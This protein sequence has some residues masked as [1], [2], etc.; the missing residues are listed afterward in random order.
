MRRQRVFL[1]GFM[2]SGK[3][4]VGPLLAA[5]L[6][7]EF[8]DLDQQIEEQQGRSIRLL[9]ELEGEAFFRQIESQALQQLKKR[10]RCVVALGGGAFALATN[11][12]TIQS[13]GYSVFLDCPLEVILKR[14][15]AD[16]SRPLLQSPEFVKDL[17]DSRRPFYELCDF[18]V[19]ASSDR[20][21]E[22]AATIS[23]LLSQRM[24]Q[25]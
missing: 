23:N 3:S 2:G 5:L 13:M 4:T 1:V 11:R 16:G 20:A 24:A 25:P 15:P 22:I 17:Y 7:W 6:N 14:C 19:D 9:F 8:Y 18:Q 21:E 12:E 10:D